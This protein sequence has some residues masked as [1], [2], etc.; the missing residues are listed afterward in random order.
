MLGIILLP[1]KE[2]TCEK[3]MYIYTHKHKGEVIVRRR[4][5]GE[6][7]PIIEGLELFTNL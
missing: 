3:Y 1:V 7:K 2:D 5:M 6:T 4:K